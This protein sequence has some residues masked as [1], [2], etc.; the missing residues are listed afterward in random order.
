MKQA[1]FFCKSGNYFLSIGIIAVLLSMSC[2]K[3]YVPPVKRDI[4]QDTTSID[5]SSVDTIKVECNDWLCRAEE[6]IDLY[7]KSDISIKALNHKGEALKGIPVTVKL[8]KHKFYFGAV[9]VEDLFIGDKADIFKPLFLK[10]FNSAG[11]P[12]GLKPKQWGNTLEQ[13]AEEAILWYLENDIKVR[14][15]TLVW[16]SESHYKPEQ[17]V[18]IFQDDTKSPQEKFEAFKSYTESFMD[19]A[20]SKW[21]VFCWDAINEPLGNHEVNDWIPENTFK[22][23]FD[24]A[25][26]YRNKRGKEDVKLFLN[27]NRVISR[28]AHSEPWVVSRQADF[29]SIIEDL[30]AKGAPIDGIGLQSRIKNGYLPPDT[31]FERLNAFNKFNLP[32]HAT[33]HEVRDGDYIYTNQEKKKIVGE[34]LTIYFSHPLV[35]G[36]WA[37]TFVDNNSERPYALFGID[38]TPYPAGEKW[39]ELLTGKFTTHETLQTDSLGK[40]VLRGF[41]GDYEISAEINGSIIVQDM[42]LEKDGLEVVL[43]P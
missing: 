27:E 25:D 15:H 43:Q 19:H 28:M 37:W 6:R 41:M 20:F 36:I 39:I 24:L 30:V 18:A 23:W 1:L 14:G 11:F 8:K 2:I 38:G 10:Y 29:I 32:L 12:N 7:R 22:L 42:V 13:N 35:D 21:D 9:V 40:V 4:K 5:T 3:E 16:E 34:L 17:Q 33:E 26:R 31:L